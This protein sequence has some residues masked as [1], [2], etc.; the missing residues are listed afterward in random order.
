MLPTGFAVTPHFGF[1]AHIENLRSLS[2][3]AIAQV[4]HRDLRH[5]SDGKS[6]LLPGCHPALQISCDIFN[7]YS[8]QSQTRF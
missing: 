6:R 8:R 4:L 7:A 3:Q 1:A 2:L 5:L